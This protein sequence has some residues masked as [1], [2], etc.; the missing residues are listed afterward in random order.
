MKIGE[1]IRKFRTARDLSQKQLGQMSGMS[2]P[3]IRNYELG[4]RY[5]GT[6]QL[7]SIAGALSISP[8]AL[9]DPDFDTYYGLIHA[10]FQL[11]DLYGLEI[12]SIDGELCLT[13]DKSRGMAY[14][15]MFDMFN[16]WQKESEKL[17]AGEITKKEYDA[18]RYTYPQI[19][20]ERAKADR[21]A[22]RAERNKR[23][24]E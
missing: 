7:E 22:R 14:L 4:N 18:W 21:D 24:N 15:S 23:D 1:R 9:A 2:E 11:E 20:A 13:L 3:A 16:A 8:F 19:E 17:K 5:P 6:K 10:L 12:K